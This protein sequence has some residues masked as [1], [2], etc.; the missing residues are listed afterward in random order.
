MSQPCLRMLCLPGRSRL[1]RRSDVEEGGETVFPAATDGTS[2]DKGA[3]LVMPRQRRRTHWCFA[4]LSSCGQHGLAV[5]PRQGDALLFWSMTLDGN[6]V[7]CAHSAATK[8]R[9]AVRTLRPSTSRILRACMPAALSYVARNGQARAH[10][11]CGTFNELTL[12]HACSN[13]V[14]ASRKNIGRIARD[15]LRES[16]GLKQHTQSSHTM[17]T[18]PRRSRQRSTQRRDECGELPQPLSCG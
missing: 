13:K 4:E 5:K 2:P 16:L 1:K 6:T 15:V 11:S 12:A 14:D 10:V 8:E 7:R 9:L 17:R 18:S 3:P